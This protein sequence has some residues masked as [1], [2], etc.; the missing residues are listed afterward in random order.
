ME[1]KV[2]ISYED[3]LKLQSDYEKEIG[4]MEELFNDVKSRT[5]EFSE[6]W[7]GNDSEK[8]MPTLKDIESKF[9]GIVEYNNKYNEYLKNVVELYK[10]YDES[11][12]KVTDNSDKTLD[13]NVE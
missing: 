6:Y 10:S 13:I 3:L 8:V 11:V 12:A 4:K 2:D 1:N 5:G 7:T 9:D